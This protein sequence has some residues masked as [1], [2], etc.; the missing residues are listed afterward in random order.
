MRPSAATQLAR[1][2]TGAAPVGLLRA[3]VAQD[4]L[5]DRPFGRARSVGHYVLAHERVAHL[6]AR[7]LQ[8][9]LVVAEDENNE[10]AC[11]R[12]Q[13]LDRRESVDLRSLNLEI[14]LSGG[15]RRIVQRITDPDAIQDCVHT[16]IVSRA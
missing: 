11:L 2:C 14:A 9:I 12:A 5:A 1:H 10:I 3:L 6:L 13:S 4:D 8:S 15:Q 16:E 7:A